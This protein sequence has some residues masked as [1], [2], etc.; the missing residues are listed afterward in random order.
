MSDEE[1]R[2]AEQRWIRQEQE[3][4]RQRDHEREDGEPSLNDLIDPRF[5]VGLGLNL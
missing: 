1:R 4:D 5:H 3:R 2:R